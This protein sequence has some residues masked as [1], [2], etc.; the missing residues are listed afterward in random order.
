M[1]SCATSHPHGPNRRS[2]MS[3]SP[4]TDTTGISMRRGSGEAAR[5]GYESLRPVIAVRNTAPIAT[6]S[7][8]DAT[9]GR[10]FT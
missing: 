6:A 2:T 5:S 7:M 8:L 3:S 1:R 4:R 10:S 9:Y